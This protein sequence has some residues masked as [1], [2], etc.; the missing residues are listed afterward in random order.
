LESGYRP[1]PGST[2]P[3]APIQ[4]EG[5]KELNILVRA[6]GKRITKLRTFTPDCELD[7]GNTRFVWFT[8]VQP[9]SSLEFLNGFVMSGSSAREDDQMRNSAAGA[10]AMHSDPAA[11]ALLEK[12]MDPTQPD[13]LRKKI[14]FWLGAVRGRKGY[15][16]LARVIK[17]DPSDSVREQ[18]THGLSVSKEPEAQTTLFAVARDDR[19][20]KVRGQALFWIAQKAGQKA[21]SAIREAIENDPQTEVKK[22]AVF[23][24]SQLPK[25]EGIPLLIDVAKNNKN[26][27]VRKQAMFWLGQSKDPRALTFFEQVLTR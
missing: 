8:G 13:S 3:P 1:G 21:A 11:D 12:Y 22:R 4:L 15:E 2:T 5:P 23:A 27:E 16:L 7:A 19:S 17:Q 20:A 10:I 14:V 6:E 26:P 9:K 18:A 25:D 24:L